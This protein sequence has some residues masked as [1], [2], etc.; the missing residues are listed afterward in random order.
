M[1]DRPG[2][3]NA[4]PGQSP[5]KHRKQAHGEREGDSGQKRPDGIES[6]GVGIGQKRTPAGYLG[7]PDRQGPLHRLGQ[8]LDAAAV[9]PADRHAAPFDDRAEHAAEAGMPLPK[10]SHEEEAREEADCAYFM[11][12]PEALDEAFVRP[13]HWIVAVYAGEVVPLEAYAV[14][15]GRETPESNDSDSSPTARL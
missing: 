3:E 8:D 5:V 6:A 10:V 11:A 14:N 2:A 7:H 4:E 13:V 12:H 15:S 9:L 1:R